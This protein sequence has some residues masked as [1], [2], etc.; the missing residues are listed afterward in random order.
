MVVNAPKQSALEKGRFALQGYFNLE[1]NK[2]FC[3]LS[4]LLGAFER[5]TFLFG[6]IPSFFEPC[7]LPLQKY[8]QR[9]FHHA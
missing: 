6:R 7:L 9:L 3:F 4:A 1:R 2:T 8:R 5:I